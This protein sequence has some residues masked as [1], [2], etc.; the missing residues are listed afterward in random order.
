ML[1]LLQKFDLLLLYKENRGENEHIFLVPSMLPAETK[2]TFDV[3]NGPQL[4]LV[5][6]E[7]PIDG[8]GELSF[9]E[10]SKGLVIRVS[11]QRASFLVCLRRPLIG[12]STRGQARCKGE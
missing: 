4:F 1:R 8:S 3:N 9:D 5:F 12:G 7:Q 6:R 11:C 10:A 2:P